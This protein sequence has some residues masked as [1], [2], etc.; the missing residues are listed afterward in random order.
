VHSDE[1]DEPKCCGQSPS[2]ELSNDGFPVVGDQTER[3]VLVTD[4]MEHQAGVQT[5]GQ[6]LGR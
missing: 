1:G 2:G 6:Q 5:G 4:L 3:D